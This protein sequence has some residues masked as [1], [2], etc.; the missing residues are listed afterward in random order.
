MT[1]SSIKNQL[2][3]IFTFAYLAAF[4]I[5]GVWQANFEFLY[6]TFLIVALIYLIIRFN[7]FLHLAFFILFNL[8]ILGF[9]NLLGGNL[10]LAGLRLYDFYLLPGLIRYDNFIHAYG[11]F[12]ATLALYSLLFNFI[13]PEIKKRYWLFAVILI[14]MAIGLGT[15][16]ELVEFLAVIFFNVAGKVGDYYNNTLDLVFNTLGSILATIIIYFYRNPPNFFKKING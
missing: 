14:L 9:L 12:I 16:V 7:K 15:I 8:S 11:T 13:N 1:N 6:Y 2:I 4:T 5:N 10:Y 3:L